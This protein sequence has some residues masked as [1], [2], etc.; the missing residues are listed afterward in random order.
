MSRERTTA[1]A[2]DPI[3]VHVGRRV[4]ELRKA[5]QMTQSDLATAVGVTFQQ[6]QK[7]ESAI[8]RLSPARLHRLAAYF[9]EPIA[10]FFPSASEEVGPLTPAGMEIA[11]LASELTPQEQATVLALVRRLARR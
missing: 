9:E 8:H 1:P 3:D 4:A 10:S 6:V 7:Y 11:L 2:P 5:R